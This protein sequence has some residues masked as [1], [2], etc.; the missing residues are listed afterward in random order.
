[1]ASWC[2][3]RNWAPRRRGSCLLPGMGRAPTAAS[4]PLESIA[5]K[6]GRKGVVEG[7]S[8]EPG[9]GGLGQRQ[10]DGSETDHGQGGAHGVRGRG[11]V[12]AGA[13]V[14][15]AGRRGGEP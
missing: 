12:G 14:R 11:S 4:C 6:R 7:K 9:G 13:G 2:G 5:L 3:S 1:M 15:G 10:E 8:L